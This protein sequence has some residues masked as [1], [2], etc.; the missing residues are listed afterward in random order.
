MEI[1][2]A[3][4]WLRQLVTSLSPQKPR[5]LNVWLV[6]DKVALGQFFLLFLWFSRQYHSTIAL[7]NS[8]T[9]WGI[10]NRP[11]GGCSSET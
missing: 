11:F 2:M 8:Y 5:P 7:Y 9:I 10:N 4:P 3:M 6:A 1:K